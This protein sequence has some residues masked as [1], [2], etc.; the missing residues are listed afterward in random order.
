MDTSTGRVLVIRFGALGD[1][2][3]TT[4]LLPGLQREGAEVTWVTKEQWAPLLAH[5]PRIHRLEVL[6]PGESLRALARRLEALGIDRVVD[7]HATLRSRMLTAL[8][9]PVPTTRLEKDTV[10]RW[11]HVAGL[12][13]S[14][15]LDRRLVDRVRALVPAA[16]PNDRPRI[17]LGTSATARA[18]GL[19]EGGRWMAVAP[20]AKHPTKQWPVERFAAVAR[21]FAAQTGC[22]V[23]VLGGPDERTAVQAVCD[24]VEDARAWPAERPLDEV[25]AALAHCDLLLGNDSG[26]VHLAEAVGTP[27]VAVFGPTVR[28]WGYFPLDPASRVIEQDVACRPCSK[29]GERACR[30]PDTWCLTRSTVEEVLEAVEDVWTRRTKPRD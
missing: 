30:Q 3:L 25:A 9:P 11:L 19:F 8:L 5:D 23:L 2:V 13:A 14:R 12:P 21:A 17:P 27:A 29:A 6:H 24:A 26:L 22:R 15:V 4:A 7:A 1:L 28:A 18:S 16:Q 20:G 10:A